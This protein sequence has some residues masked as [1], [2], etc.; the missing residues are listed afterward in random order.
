MRKAI[1]ISSLILGLLVVASFK[2]SNPNAI[3]L[4][5]SERPSHWSYVFLDIN[6]TPNAKIISAK[7]GLMM[8]RP[9]CARPINA[10][11]FIQK[12]LTC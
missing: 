1:F 4:T 7:V 3:T 11:E 10:L 12:Y 5:P 8:D 6:D 2:S 9:V